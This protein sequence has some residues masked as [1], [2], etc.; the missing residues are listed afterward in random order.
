MFFIVKKKFLKY[1]N[2]KNRNYSFEKD[3][4]IKSLKLK[5]LIAYR[6]NQQYFTITNI[7]MLKKFENYIKNKQ[8]KYEKNL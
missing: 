7:K 1:F 4:L 3:I 2:K 8:L 6:T 5:K